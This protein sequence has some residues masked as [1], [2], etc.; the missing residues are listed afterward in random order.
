MRTLILIALFTLSAFPQDYEQFNQPST[1][2]Q[3]KELFRRE[4]PEGRRELWRIHLRTSLKKY[5]LN[6]EQKKLIRALIKAETPDQIQVIM[7]GV[8]STFSFEL[9]RKIFYTLGDADTLISAEGEQILDCNCSTKSYN[10]SCYD[11]CAIPSHPPCNVVDG[12]GVFW[13]FICNGKCATGP[14]S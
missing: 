5:K 14:V 12:C 1:I 3:R 9:G 8:R 7:D 6:T 13:M 10:Y 2:E 11:Y 4:S